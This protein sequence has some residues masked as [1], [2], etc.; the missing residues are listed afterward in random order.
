VRI[1]I[2]CSGGGLRSASFSLGVLSDLWEEGVFKNPVTLSAVSGGNYAAI[3]FLTTAATS[4]TIRARRSSPDILPDGDPSA[5]SG[6]SL[7]T[8]QGDPKSEPTPALWAIDSPEM[9]ALR[10]EC[11]DVAASL[12]NRLWLILLIARSMLINIL[13][14]VAA[15]L[16]VGHLLG[17]LDV[18]L[19]S[20]HTP[21][22]NVW[23]TAGLLIMAPLGVAVL[24]VA[25]AGSGHRYLEHKL[26]TSGAQRLSIVSI[27]L[28]TILAAIEI[29][30]SI[31]DLVHDD[32]VKDL[33]LHR[34]V[35]LGLFPSVGT[36][37][38]AVLVGLFIVSLVVLG[39]VT[40]G[41]PRPWRRRVRTSVA[42]STALIIV[43]VPCV[44][45]FD[46]ARVFS[47]GVIYR[48][49]LVDCV[50][51]LLFGIAFDANAYSLFPI[52]RA[53]LRRAFFWRRV[54]RDVSI[55]PSDKDEATGGESLSRMSLSQLHAKIAAF[56]GG[57]GNIH[58]DTRV[59]SCSAVGLSDRTSRDGRAFESFVFG[60]S[61]GS[62]ATGR[63]RSDWYEPAA[64]PSRE[65]LDLAAVMAISGAAV[66]PTMGRFSRNGTR[67]L[68]ALL[69]LRFGVW[70]RNP[71]SIVGPGQTLPPRSV[72]RRVFRRPSLVN[73]CLEAVSSLTGSGPS[74]FVSDGGHFE[75]LGLVE[76]VVESGKDCKVVIS[77]DASLEARR[78]LSSFYYALGLLRSLGFECTFDEAPVFDPESDKMLSPVIAGWITRPDGNR[79][80][81]IYLRCELYEGM[82]PHLGEFAGRNGY[83]PR[84]PTIYQFLSADVVDAYYLLGRDIARKAGVGTTILD[85]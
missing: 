15:S 25:F 1:G 28:G 63:I 26:S 76:L 48:V 31:L 55:F 16:L 29:G 53:R 34:Y 27:A 61:T 77:I 38:V 67:L 84:H 56:R 35:V 42:F 9:R 7:N 74:V 82:A 49:V 54:G 18:V 4:Q 80:R 30:P 50:V 66:S 64:L 23:V 3:A 39:G 33:A 8:A 52:Y 83:F 72:A 13:P 69:N 81:L 70:L 5:P 19:V 2:A 58:P 47:T 85:F 73:V 20:N 36:R 51:L 37:S 32:S 62:N 24:A 44:W 75:N 43:G 14:A 12:L 78:S 46:A 40:V 6:S 57:D 17:L 45:A 59:V 22:V 68:L 65:C 79:V 10:V 71:N 21:A 60:E 11:D 41:S